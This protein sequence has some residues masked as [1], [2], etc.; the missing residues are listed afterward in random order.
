M[1][2]DILTRLNASLIRLLNKNY[3]QGSFRYLNISAIID[4]SDHGTIIRTGIRDSLKSGPG[5]LR[6]EIL[7]R[8]SLKSG[9]EIWDPETRDSGI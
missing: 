8:D 3:Y 2:L 1:G 6:P 7:G 5:N 4:R 9:P